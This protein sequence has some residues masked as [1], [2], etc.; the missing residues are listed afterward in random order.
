MAITA[1][2]IDI[3]LPFFAQIRTAMQT[4]ND[5]VHATIT[6]NIFFLGIGQMLFG[7]LS[8]RY[9]R[10]P[11]VAT[12]LSIYL[13]GALVCVFSPNIETLLVGRALQGLGAGA[14]PVV[15]RAIIRDRFTGKQIA[16]NMALAAGIFSIGP[17]AAPLVGA[18]LI[19]LGGDWHIIF[20]AMALMASA[21]MAALLRLPETLA[22]PQLDALRPAAIR[23][24]IGTILAHPQSRYFLLLSGWT[25]VS[26]VT[27]ISGMA[28]VMESAFDVTG[29]LFAVLF[30]AHGLGIIIGQYCNHWLIGRFGTLAASIYGAVVMTTALSALVVLSAA[31][32]VNAYGVS[33][34][35]V[36]YAVGYLPVYSNAA[37]L[38][39]EPHGRIAGFTAAFYGS[40]GQLFSALAASVVLI[41]SGGRLVDWSLALA[42]IA[43]VTLIGL[44]VWQRAVRAAGQRSAV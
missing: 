1:F 19:E 7:S 33:A 40:F 42:G 10:R 23:R 34:L 28:R 4:S 8:D 11:A 20:V 35:I 31:D 5:L 17:I 39:L 16:Q 13:L 9:G 24:N 41:A 29:T 14:A 30:A 2:S 22:S 26:I 3:T 15:A 36:L 43:A 18:V 21:L 12:G 37:S 27:I 6:L 38:T 25:M 44:L 32:M